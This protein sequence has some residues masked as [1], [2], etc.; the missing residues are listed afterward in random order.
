[1]ATANFYNKNASN[2]YAIL[3]ENE[4]YYFIF[5]DVKNNI[6]NDLEAYTKNSKAYLGYSNKY[7][8]DASL[9]EVISATDEVAGVPFTVS[10]EVLMRPGY[11]EGANLDYEINYNVESV[12]FDDLSEAFQ[13]YFDVAAWDFDMNK[14][15]AKIQA[16]NAA[17][18]LEAMSNELVENVE[19]ILKKN[20]THILQVSARFSN[21]ETWYSEVKTA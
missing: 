17:K 12:E 20:C 7:Y 3:P 10:V 1:M 21:G 19:N 8:R 14:G 15:L 4:D 13:A 6:S 18:R 5:D 2:I 11:Y 16:K 9:I